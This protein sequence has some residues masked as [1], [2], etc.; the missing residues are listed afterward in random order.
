MPGGC[1]NHLLAP[2]GLWLTH[3][4]FILTSMCF[5]FTISNELLLIKKRRTFSLD[6]LLIPSN[7]SERHLDF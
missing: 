3:Q 7:T 6:S 4:C 1:F 2:F 5:N